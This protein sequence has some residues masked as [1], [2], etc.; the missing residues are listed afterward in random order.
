M[1]KIPIEAAKKI[2]KSYGY[3]QVIIYARKVDTEDLVGGE[4]M[5]SYGVNPA[6]CQAAAVICDFLKTK[7][8]GWP[9]K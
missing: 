1:K 9:Q 2:A 8:M 7:I 6:H 5:T 3:D 4:H